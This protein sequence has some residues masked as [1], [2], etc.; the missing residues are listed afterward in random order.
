[1]K[2]LIA[3]DDPIV[4]QLLE[5]SIANWGYEV[6][7]VEDGDGAW[8]VLDQP[9]APRL[10]ILD[11]VMPNR[12]GV[13]ICQDIRT[14]RDHPYTYLVLLTSKNGKSEMIEGLN[15]GADDYLTKPVDLNELRVRLQSGQRILTL[16]ADL[17]AAR[18]ALYQQAMH[19][20]L[21][22]LLNRAAIAQALEQELM[23]A[24]R[25]HTP[26]GVIVADLDH[27]KQVNDRYGH[28]AGDRV[29]METAQRI[30]AVVRPYDRV[31]RYGG[32]EFLILC[33]GCT[34]QDAVQVA[35]RIRK[36]IEHHP[37]E[38]SSQETIT[39]TIC[40]GVT[41]SGADEAQDPTLLVQYADRALYQAKD[42]G[43]NRAEVMMAD[44]SP[45][46]DP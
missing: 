26:L 15:A 28:L 44:V 22:G 8:E 10:A 19:D 30:R 7:A 35:E 13:A 12:D 45:Q 24:A 6:V 2:I 38:I 5:T 9:D 39:V 41:A 27:F 23:R 36:S 37:I 34:E 40:L 43:R 29:L 21:T 4:R 42:R 18:D 46:S 17:V 25:Q 33:P 14:R 1:M 16:Q 20:A 31:G 32:E 3:D 11:W